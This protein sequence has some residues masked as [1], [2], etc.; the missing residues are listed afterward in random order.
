MPTML[1]TIHAP[2]TM[3]YPSLVEM[4]SV[5][6]TKIMGKHPNSSVSNDDMRRG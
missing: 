6:G 5:R 4:R 2:T 1:D 3:Q